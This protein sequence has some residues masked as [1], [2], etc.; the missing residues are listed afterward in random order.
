M[1][2]MRIEPKECPHLMREIEIWLNRLFFFVYLTPFLVVRITLCRMIECL[3][4][5]VLGRVW[6]ETDMNSMD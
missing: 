5:S 1:K 3:L 2:P 6:D 4:N